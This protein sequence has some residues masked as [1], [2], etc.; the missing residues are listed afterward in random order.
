MAKFLCT[1]GATIRTSGLIPNPQQWLLASDESLNRFQGQ[2][3][4]ETVYSAMLH[5]FRCDE[6]ARMWVFWKGY[7]ADPTEYVPQ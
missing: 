7:D 3:D 1:C 6:C 2:V 5:A 4:A